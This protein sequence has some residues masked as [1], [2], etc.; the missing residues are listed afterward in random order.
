MPR[1]S[2][3]NLFLCRSHCSDGMH[4]FQDGSD[5]ARIKALALASELTARTQQQYQQC[6]C[7]M[8]VAQTPQHILPTRGANISGHRTKLPLKRFKQARLSTREW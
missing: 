5:T 8:N 7:P 3:V 4:G 2:A 1:N 6:P